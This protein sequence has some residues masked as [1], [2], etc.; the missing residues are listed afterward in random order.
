MSATS[1][2]IAFLGAVAL[3]SAPAMADFDPMTGGS[4]TFY[5]NGVALP[6]F[7]TNTQVKLTTIS[8]SSVGGAFNVSLLK[9]SLAGS[10]YGSATPVANNIFTTYCVERDV[11]FTPGTAYWA[12]IDVKAYSGGLAG[13]GGDPISNVTEHIYGNWLNGMADDATGWQNLGF[14]SKAD[15]MAHQADVSQAIWWAE[16]ENTGVKNNIAN[17]MLQALYGTTAKTPGQLSASQHVFA[18]NLW[19]ISRFDPAGS[20][21]LD[22]YATD[23]QTQL[24]KVGDFHPVPAPGAVM[25]GL[26]GF[27]L[28]GW[29]RRRFA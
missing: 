26:V 2:A 19:S 15:M 24:I 6:G 12:T 18:L 10:V 16:G 17:L 13:T 20:L 21:P 11:T 7:S 25:L 14:T 5:R 23:V 8:G 3:L 1:K 4:F 28:I 27:G 29:I 9:G 22:W